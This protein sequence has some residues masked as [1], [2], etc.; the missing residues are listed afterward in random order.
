MEYIATFY[1]QYGAIKF[2]RELQKQGGHV[3][4]MPIPRQLSSSCGTCVRFNGTAGQSFDPAG[5]PADLRRDFEALYALHEGHPK[6]VWQN[7][8]A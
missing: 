8:E 2:Y 1:T 6:R 4:L 3:K 7:E 5:C